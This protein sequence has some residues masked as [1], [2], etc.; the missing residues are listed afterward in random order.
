MR[1]KKSLWKR[2]NWVQRVYWLSL[3]C[4]S[5]LSIVAYFKLDDVSWLIIALL[6][7]MLWDTTTI[8]FEL[9]ELRR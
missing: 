3:P 7:L 9:R 4:V 6:E 8:E 5:V 1:R 2:M